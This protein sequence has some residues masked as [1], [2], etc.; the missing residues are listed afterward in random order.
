VTPPLEA[1]NGKIFWKFGRSHDPFGPPGYAYGLDA[2]AKQNKIR[3]F[4]AFKFK[5]IFVNRKISQLG[6]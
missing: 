5:P 6:Q 1:Q 4:F 3:E 2:T